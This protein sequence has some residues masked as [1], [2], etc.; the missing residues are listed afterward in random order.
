MEKH[1]LEGLEV[2]LFLMVDIQIKLRIK[3]AKYIS[4][5][6]LEFLSVNLMKMKE[7]LKPLNF[8]GGIKTMWYC[9]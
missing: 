9:N 2:L 1:T 8:T 6:H 7:F 5:K 4:Q 3:M